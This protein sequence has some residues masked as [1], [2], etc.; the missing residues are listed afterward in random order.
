M[1]G[2][3]EKDMQAVVNTYDLKNYYYPSLFPITSQK[4]LTWKIIE[5]Q[6]GLKVAAD[7]HAFNASIVKKE[8]GVASRVDGDI[9][10]IAISREK[11]EE[12]LNEYNT[13]KALADNE[14]DLKRLVEMWAEDSDFCWAGVANRLEWIAL[15]QIS[16]GKVKF[17]NSN[18]AAIATQYDLDYEIPSAQKLG[19]NTAW[20]S[21]S[22]AKSI[23]DFKRAIKAG[24]DANANL[25]FAF[26]NLN[27]F[28]NLVEQEDIIKRSA[29]F[30][31]N[32]LSISQTPDLG[33][34]NSMLARQ[35]NINGLQIVLIDQDITLELANGDQVTENPFEDNVVLFSE[36]KV[37][38]KTFH[39]PLADESVV[40]S[41]ALKTKRGHTLIK[42]FAR[43]EPTVTEVTQGLANAFPAWMRAGRSVLMQTDK[44]TWTK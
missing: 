25:K 32:A 7:V 40:G 35:V 44:T 39:A 37:L 19:I 41:V 24:K 22:G 13:L 3:Q 27:T 15:K 10:K 26:M 38:G 31:N 16:L 20:N 29:S 14:E 28:A 5:A 43:E 12:F 9:P 21:T 23:E 18:N 6:S 36:S 33:L 2:L 1:Q 17:T 30:A 34:V 4:T 11:T 42:K 8:R